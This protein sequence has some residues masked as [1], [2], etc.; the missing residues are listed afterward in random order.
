MTQKSEL[1]LVPMTAA[2]VPEVALLE[3]ICFSDPWSQAALRAELEEPTSAWLVAV[4]GKRPVGYIGL[5]VVQDEGEI[6]NLAVS[7]AWRKKGV[8][9]AL[10]EVLAEFGRQL[11][12]VPELRAGEPQYPVA[13]AVGEKLAGDYVA[14]VC[15]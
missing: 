15:V 12:S 2:L 9:A 4:E 11:T 5:R 6:V 1:R 8:A 14:R 13:R 10:L 3:Q 7:P